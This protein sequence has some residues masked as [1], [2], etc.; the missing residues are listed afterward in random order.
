MDRVLTTTQRQDETEVYT[1]DYSDR[2]DPGVTISSSAW[3]ADGGVTTSSASATTTT[4]TVTVAGTGGTITNTLT[5]SNSKT[6]EFVYRFRT[7]VE[8]AQA[9]AYS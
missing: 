4:T 6:L 9:D 7:P 3:E 2:L 1:F 5:L 8:N